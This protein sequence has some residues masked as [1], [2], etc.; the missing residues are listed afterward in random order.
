VAVSTRTLL[1]V[2]R[3]STTFL[4]QHGSTSA[5]LDAELLAARALRLRRIDL[6]LQFDRPLRDD[7]LESVREM[8]RRRGHGEPVAY[9]TGV[10]EFYGREF[11][12]SRDVLIPRPET[13]TLVQ[14]AL[15]HIRAVPDGRSVLRVADLGT[16]SGCI[17]VT[18]ACELPDIRLTA[19]DVSGAALEVA[20]ANASRHGVSER[21]TFVETSWADAVDGPIDVVVSNPPY[22]TDDE[23]AE[24]ERDV[25]AFEPETA[26]LGGE[27]GLHAYRALLESIRDRLNAE[28]AVF[29]EVDPRR[30]GAVLELM[31]AALPGSSTA[32][33][34]DLMGRA[35]VAACVKRAPSLLGPGVKG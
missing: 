10:R 25:R 33:H 13:E 22:V 1:E 11:A 2:V 8:V 6:Y 35:R 7:E 27:D 3:L 12:V 32:L 19:T 5:R 4:A 9:I 21:I 29:V 31:Q 23:L 28:S 24:T 17:A 20:R 14:V 18:L 34:A 26:L 30:A 15:D 16:G